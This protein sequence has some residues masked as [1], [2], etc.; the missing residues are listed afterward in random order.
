MTH[1]HLEATVPTHG[2][3]R[4]SVRGLFHR[5]RSPLP[6]EEDMDV[7]VAKR[8]GTPLKRC[9]WG[10]LGLLQEVFGGFVSGR[11]DNYQLCTQHR[12]CFPC[13]RKPPLFT[14]QTPSKNTKPQGKHQNKPP[15]P[16]TLFAQWPVPSRFF[17]MREEL[18]C[19]QDEGPAKAGAA[20][21]SFRPSKPGMFCCPVLCF[22]IYQRILMIKA[23]AH[24]H[25]SSF[26]GQKE[27]LGHPT[28]QV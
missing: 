3:K 22:E 1:G 24:Y 5:G 4:P 9:F 23:M 17:W 26:S 10:L 13:K 18:P 12:A 20:S 11:Q 21:Y 7:Y 16:F 8:R 15:G 27:V 28:C 14:Y 25:E 2:G 6:K 19:R